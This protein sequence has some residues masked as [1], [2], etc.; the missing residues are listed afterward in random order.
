MTW[1]AHKDGGNTALHVV[2]YVPNIANAFEG[3][4]ITIH[5]TK[6]SHVSLYPRLKCPVKRLTQFF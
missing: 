2:N 4:S 5:G 6:A 1:F 3:F